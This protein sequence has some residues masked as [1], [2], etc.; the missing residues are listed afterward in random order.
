MVSSRMTRW[1][2]PNCGIPRT[3][4]W[5]GR[6]RCQCGTATATSRPLFPYLEHRR[7][8]GTLR[9]WS[10][11]DATW[12]L[13]QNGIRVSTP[14]PSGGLLV[15]VWPWDAGVFSVYRPDPI[16]LAN[17]DTLSVVRSLTV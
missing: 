10:L 6:T 1:W 4:G 8:D 2:C 7:P 3:D 11:R 14:T 13:T 16:R 15:R 9:Y 17:G 5:D 12:T